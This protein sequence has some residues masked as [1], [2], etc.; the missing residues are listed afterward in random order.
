MARY[1]ES[2]TVTVE[3]S[4]AEIEQ[5]VRKYGAQKFASGYDE[6]T[7]TA[8]IQFEMRDRRDF[9]R[10]TIPDANDGQ[11]RR[12]GRGYARTDAARIRAHAQE[13][14]RL[15]RALFMVIKAKLE[16]VESGIES[17]EEAFLSQLVIPGAGGRTYGDYAIPQIAHVYA[18]GTLPPLLPGIEPNDIPALGPGGGYCA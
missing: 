17:F 15:W 10:L 18:T 3:K 13:E 9:F 5:I 6:D 4:K 16:S 2:T 8:V 7:G 1:A 12:D 11:F 14:R